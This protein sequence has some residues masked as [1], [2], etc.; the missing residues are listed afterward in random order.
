MYRLM[1]VACLASNNIGLRHHVV[2]HLLIKEQLILSIIT[3]VC[4]VKWYA[5][6]LLVRKKHQTVCRRH[7]F[8]VMT[9]EVSTDSNLG[10]EGCI[11]ISTLGV[12][13]GILLCCRY[14]SRTLCTLKHNFI[15]FQTLLNLHRI[16]SEHPS[17]FSKDTQMQCITLHRQ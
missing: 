9:L 14:Y 4:G 1:L 3:Y 6:S 17:Y 7:W 13:C 12:L 15:V 16:I 5:V 10:S 2:L 8:T 11:T